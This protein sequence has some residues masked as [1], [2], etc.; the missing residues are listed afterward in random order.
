MYE[1]ILALLFVCAFLYDKFTVM[2]SV[3][4]LIAVII[5]FLYEISAIDLITYKI[6]FMLLIVITAAYMTINFAIRK[7]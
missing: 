7:E 6:S 4:F 2:Q 5:Y 1:F 3:T